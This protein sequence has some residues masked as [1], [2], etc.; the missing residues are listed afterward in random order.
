[1][2]VGVG[3]EGGA[4][5]GAWGEKGARA[6]VV[7]EREQGQ[8]T[9]RQRVVATGPEHPDNGTGCGLAKPP[10]PGMRRAQ[11][12]GPSRAV[13]VHSMAWPADMQSRCEHHRASLWA[14]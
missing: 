12:E 14:F 2:G 4:W 11:Q 7:Q 5:A 1:M 9:A 6:G 13:G 10:N 8:G 3:A